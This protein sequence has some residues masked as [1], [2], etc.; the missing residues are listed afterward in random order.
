MTEKIHQVLGCVQSWMKIEKKGW[1]YRF[2][3]FIG[4]L[5]KEFQPRLTMTNGWTVIPNHDLRRQK[6]TDDT[7]LLSM[8]R[9]R[10]VTTHLNGSLI[11]VRDGMSENMVQ[12]LPIWKTTLGMTSQ[13]MLLQWQKSRLQSCPHEHIHSQEHYK[14]MSEKQITQYCSLKKRTLQTFVVS[15]SAH[16]KLL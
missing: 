14:L 6:K 12:A 10:P 7:G 4:V 11:K 16:Y 13:Q 2:Q 9:Y 1:P 8:G 3:A 5:L 15:K